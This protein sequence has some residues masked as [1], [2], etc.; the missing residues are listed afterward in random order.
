MSEFAGFDFGAFDEEALDRLTSDYIAD[1][2][3]GDPFGE[4]MAE[5]FIPTGPRAD[6]P[7]DLPL[8][9]QLV[10]PP[11]PPIEERKSIGMKA[12]RGWTQSEQARAI[13]ARRADEAKDAAEAKAAAAPK[14]RKSW[15]LK[16]PHMQSSKSERRAL[17]RAQDADALQHGTEEEKAK[18]AAK[19]AKAAAATAR[20]K[21]KRLANMTES[22]RTKFT[23]QQSASQAA[24]RAKKQAGHG[25]RK[26]TS[27]KPTKK[28]H[29]LK[30]HVLKKRKLR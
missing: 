9:L 22:Q 26:K 16:S 3:R 8:P 25:R 10:P 18:I 19:R 6:L 12:P 11:A 7:G 4:A 2:L 13:A 5:S 30:K 17:E 24:R 29:V 21:A 27:V 23:A 28:R 1:G 14:K 20:S 15:A